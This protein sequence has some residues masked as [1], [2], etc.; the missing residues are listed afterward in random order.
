LLAGCSSDSNTVNNSDTNT[1]SA[2]LGVPIYPGAEK[3]NT[4][5]GATSRPDGSAPSSAD[6][7]PQP[8]DMQGS[9]PQGGPPPD[10]QGSMPQ[11]SMPQPP[12][13]G[14]DGNAQGPG[15]MSGTLAV[16][17]TEDST[18][19]VI[20]WYRDKLKD[21]TDFQEMTQP[22]GSSAPS[23]QS[24]VSTAMF[25]VTVNGQSRTVMVRPASTGSSSTGGTMI[26][27]GEGMQGGTAQQQ[28]Q[29]SVT[30]G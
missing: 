7:R 13:G 14:P 22:A 4:N 9:M 15:G 24:T 2:S 28:N 12:N 16:Y 20:S 8:P 23:G 21:M 18:D 11:G 19:Q 1:T 30:P 27:I 29:N 17:T 26:I 3:Q 5:A 10:M 25:S 6:G